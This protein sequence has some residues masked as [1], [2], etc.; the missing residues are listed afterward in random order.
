MALIKCLTE[1][2]EIIRLDFGEIFATLVEI[3][4]NVGK[5]I[6]SL[7]CNLPKIYPVY[8]K[9]YKEIIA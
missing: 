7:A 3:N 8:I 6:F 5:I 1:I 2:V 4:N 9:G